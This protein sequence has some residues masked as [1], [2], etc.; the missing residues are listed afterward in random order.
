MLNMKWCKSIYSTEFHFSFKLT[1][2]KL[3]VLEISGI[4]GI[5]TELFFY[6]FE[7]ND[8]HLSLGDLECRSDHSF[9]KN[10]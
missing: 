1:F 7:L 10:L 5:L 6:G 8:C 9:T 4:S 2:N 3:L